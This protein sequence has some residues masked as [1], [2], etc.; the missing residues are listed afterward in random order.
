MHARTAAR[1]L[2]LLLLG[3]VA[4]GCADDSKDKLL[5]SA[6]R[7][8]A[9]GDAAAAVVELKRALAKD[10]ASPKTRALLGQALLDS[11]DPAAAQVELGRALE[12]GASPEQVLP[13]L[14]K[15]L[16]LLGQPTKVTGSY[17]STTLA[18]PGAEAELKTCVAAAYSQQGQTE[19]AYRALDAALRA[20][21]LFPAA[22][23]VQARMR[24]RDE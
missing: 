17:G 8:L 9:R 5:A 10:E 20:H 3:A 4:S 14:A 21:P 2:A 1:L 6:R 22:V 13:A 23:I 24:A 19:Q 15:A 7:Y 12:Q 16:L 11:G 18:E